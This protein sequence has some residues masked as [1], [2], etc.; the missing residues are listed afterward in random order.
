VESERRASLEDSLDPPYE[1]AT[2]MVQW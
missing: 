1:R 2:E